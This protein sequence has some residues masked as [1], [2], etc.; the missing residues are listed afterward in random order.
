MTR[1]AILEDIRRLAQENGGHIGLRAF[2]R[3]SGIPEHQVVPGQF[4]KW[5]AALAVAGIATVSFR[6]PRTEEVTILDAVARLAVRLEEWPS[7]NA[8]K[9]ERQKSPSFPSF[10][11]I[12]R[13]IRNRTLASKVAAYCV[14][15]SELARAEKLA[16]ERSIIESVETPRP[17]RQ[18]IEGYVYLMRSGR[19]YK[20]GFTSSPSRRHREVRLDLPDPTDL[21]HSIPTDD[22]AGIERYWHERFKSKRIRET[23]FFTLD[24]TDVAAFRSRKYQ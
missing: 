4:V 16:R 24:A 1:E 6:R 2:C 18:A 20:I 9:F 15:K 5:N 12:R 7:E 19:R 11:V 13:L 21:V 14:G 17:G 22:P 3:K 23:E 10:S 8:M